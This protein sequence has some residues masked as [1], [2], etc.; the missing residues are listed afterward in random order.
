MTVLLLALGVIWFIWFI[1]PENNGDLRV[2]TTQPVDGAQ[3]VPARTDIRITFNQPLTGTGALLTLTP[4]VSGTTH[5]QGDVLIFSPQAALAA[6]TNY[7]VKLAAGVQGQPGSAL[8]QAVSWQF[9][10]RPL[11]LLYIAADD[12][13]ADQIF[14][15]DP[16]SSKVSQLTT[17]VY[18][19]FDYRLSPDGTTI[20][21]S[22]LRADGGSDLGAISPD[23]NHR[24]LLLACANAACSGPT[25]APDSRRILF[26]KRS[27]SNPDAPRLWWLNVAGGESSPMFDDAQILGYGA[28]WSPT[29][30]WLA[31]VAPAR[32]AVQIYNL[33][34]N[35]SLLVPSRSGGLAVWSPQGD[36][37]LVTDIQPSAAGVAMHLLRATPDAGKL[38]DISGDGAP[39]EDSSPAWS[40][41]G[42][43]IALTRKATGASMGKQ[44]WLM[45]P[46]G[47]DAHFLTNDPAVHFG[48]PRWSPDGRMLAY[49]RFPL[50]QLDARTSIWLMDMET[51]K[52]HQ[53][54]DNGNRP[55]W[56]P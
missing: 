18:G 47:S 22:T 7:M 15:I 48:L 2:V 23:G 34:S 43:W 28:S 51:G 40:P 56:L 29:G 32:Q 8:K 41:D 36:T 39:V 9:R 21:F 1:W 25:Y 10:T 37:F 31:F 50:Q 46:D 27:L 55:F 26:E 30:E 38:V 5:W 53:L 6:N 20:A 16:A 44:L 19:V 14:K 54:V 24:R 52:T 4:P 45:H 35:Q 12:S 17:E 11:H 13:G 33:A 3:N 49:Q 42:R